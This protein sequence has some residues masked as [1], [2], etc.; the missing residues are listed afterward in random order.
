MKVYMLKDVERVGLDGELIKVPEGYARNYLIP[1]KF[2]EAVTP[3]REALYAKKAVT[4]SMRD[5]S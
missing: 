1:R 2:A 5:S 3:D 4:V